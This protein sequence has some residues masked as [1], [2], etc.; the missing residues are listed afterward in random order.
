[1]LG[2]ASAEAPTGTSVRTVSV[3]GVAIVPIAQGANAA[4]ATAVYRQ[5]MAGAVADGQS[6]AEFL[7]SKAGATLGSVQ[8]IVEGGGYIGCTDESGYVEY[9]G[10]QPDFGSPAGTISPGRLAA[11][12]APPTSVPPVRRPS[13]HRRHKAPPAKKAAAGA[14]TLTAQVA[15]VYSIS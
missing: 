10:E 15:V 9:Q 11:G 3:Q 4:A 8:S 6:K 12:T 13:R 5:G 7:A 1:M 14:C 2:V